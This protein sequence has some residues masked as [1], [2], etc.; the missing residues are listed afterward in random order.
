MVWTCPVMCSLEYQ[1]IEKS[2]HLGNGGGGPRMHE[3]L[4]EGGGVLIVARSGRQN[5]DVFRE[6]LHVGL[7]SLE[8]AA[9]PDGGGRRLPAG[10]WHG[11]KVQEDPRGRLLQE[12]LGSH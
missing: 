10:L 4:G 3:E 11:P 2:Q 5:Y 9:R 7:A 1:A 12:Q 6:L 8:R